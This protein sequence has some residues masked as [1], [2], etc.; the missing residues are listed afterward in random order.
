[1]DVHIIIFPCFCEIIYV[2]DSF[3][4]YHKSDGCMKMHLIKC[5]SLYMV[6]AGMVCTLHKNVDTMKQKYLLNIPSYQESFL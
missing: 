4:K 3:N 1:M 5:Y 6:G 2:V